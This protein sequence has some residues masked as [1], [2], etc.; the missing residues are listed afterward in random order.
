[1][2]LI[3]PFNYFQWCTERADGKIFNLFRFVWSIAIHFHWKE[4]NRKQRRKERKEKRAKH[5]AEPIAAKWEVGKQ[6]NCSHRARNNL[7]IFCALSTSCLSGRIKNSERESFDLSTHVMMYN[8]DKDY[9][10]SRK[11]IFAVIASMFRMACSGY[12][13][14]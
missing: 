11:L 6:W 8:V 3:K 9:N 12:L 1:M 14:Q 4:N 7:T 13:K 10:V 2:N 5:G